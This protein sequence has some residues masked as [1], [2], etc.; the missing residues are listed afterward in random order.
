MGKQARLTAT[1]RA[2]AARRRD[3]MT[4]W[5]AE[6]IPLAEQAAE[7]FQ[8]DPEAAGLVARDRPAQE[9][10]LRAAGWQPNPQSSAVVDGLGCWDRYRGHPMRLVHS[11]HRYEEDG[12]VWAHLSVSLASGLL[13]SWEQLRDAQ[14]LLYPDQAGIVVIAPAGEHYSI[15]EVAHVWTCLTSRPLPDF[16][17]AG[18]I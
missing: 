7:A 8:A 1:R 13:P 4:A 2:M 10:R 18:G 14:W 17:I 6:R 12:Q 11:L 3:Q 15:G 5:V 9:R 16:R